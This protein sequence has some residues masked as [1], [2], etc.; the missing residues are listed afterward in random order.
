MQ[1]IKN[2]EMW[3]GGCCGLRASGRPSS[4]LRAVGQGCGPWRAED[5]C[6]G[7]KKQRAQRPWGGNEYG[8]GGD[9]KL[10]P[11]GPGRE[12]NEM[13]SERGEGWRKLL[14]RWGQVT[15]ALAQREEQKLG[16]IPP[17]SPSHACS[18]QYSAFLFSTNR[19]MTTKKLNKKGHLPNQE[20][21]R[22]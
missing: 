14:R 20:G 1:R 18:F 22:S 8:C 5:K 3:P 9:R 12:W 13:R 15:S 6:C 4:E 7:Q 21:Q 10:R 16:V 19:H 11:S 2:R 17:A